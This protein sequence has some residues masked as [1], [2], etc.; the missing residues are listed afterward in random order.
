MSLIK[1]VTVSSFVQSGNFEILTLTG[2]EP[3]TLRVAVRHHT[4][5]T[6]FPYENFSK[7]FQS[8]FKRYLQF[9]VAESPVRSKNNRQ[10]LSKRQKQ[11]LIITFDPDKIIAWNFQDVWK[12]T[13]SNFCQINLLWESCFVK[14]WITLICSE[15]T[16]KSSTFRGKTL[17]PG[18]L[19]PICHKT[20]QENFFH[21]CWNF[22]LA[23]CQEKHPG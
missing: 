22:S 5:Y 20:W 3:A 12:S 11:E 2:F 17:L 1:K 16:G 4:H 18:Q 6:K 21:G 10:F 19:V 8:Y 15:L 7:N 9:F 14:K 23:E 13:M